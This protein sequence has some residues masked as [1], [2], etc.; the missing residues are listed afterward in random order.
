MSLTRQLIAKIW[1]EVE[2]EPEQQNEQP[3]KEK[4]QFDKKAWLEKAESWL[5]AQTNRIKK[6]N[7]ALLL[8]WLHHNVDKE[9]KLWATYRYISNSLSWTPKKVE[10][11]IKRLQKA[12]LLKVKNDNHDNRTI[13]TLLNEETSFKMMRRPQSKKRGD[14]KA[15]Y[16]CKSETLRGDLET[17]HGETLLKNMGSNIYNRYIPIRKRSNNILTR[18][19]NL[20]RKEESKN[21]DRER[22]E[23]VITLNDEL[24][25]PEPETPCAS[26]LNRRQDNFCIRYKVFLKDYKVNSCPHWTPIN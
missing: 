9:G 21:L 16:S 13:I 2:A 25:D 24:L 23:K 3:L 5:F 10:A 22:E 12:G 7:Y 11:M 20:P 8:L 6:S 17:K 4:R 1:D 14:L 15:D 26:C 19:E 18:K